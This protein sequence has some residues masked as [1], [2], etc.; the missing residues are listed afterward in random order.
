MGH[1][2]VM[3]VD[4]HRQHVD[5][6]AVAAQQD[7]VV[8]LVVADHDVALDDVADHGLAV[9]GRLDADRRGDAGRGVGG[10]AVAPAA[11]VARRLAFGART[12]AHLLQLL[13]GAVAAIG[14]ALAQ[15]FMG[16]LGMA[17]GAR[18]L[19]DD[20]AIPV[21]LQPAQAFEDRVD[22]RLGRPL[23][24]GVLDAQAE[25]AAVMAREQPVEQGGAR[26]ADVQEAGGRWREAADGNGHVV[27]RSE[28]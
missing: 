5:R 10:I 26:A 19:V 14:L 2:H 22:R 18:E 21:Q 11:V 8:E 15:Q 16:D 24:V 27:I 23:P 28:N 20:L 17:R 3:V 1:A 9:A 7:H 25:D 12:G 4:H 13:G 6:G